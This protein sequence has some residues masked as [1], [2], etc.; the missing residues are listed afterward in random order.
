MKKILGEKFGRL[1]NSR[2]T[3]GENGQTIYRV[4]A[5]GTVSELKIRWQYFLI[6]DVNDRRASAAFT[7]EE[8]LADR[9]GSGGEAVVKTLVFTKSGPSEQ[10]V[11]KTPAPIAD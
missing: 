6:T 9:F 7:L 5:A 11:T 3:E 8:D 10:P 1:I 2:Q 4:E